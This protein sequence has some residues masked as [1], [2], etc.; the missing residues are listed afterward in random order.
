MEAINQESREAKDPMQVVILTGLSGAGKTNAAAWFE[1]EGYYCVDNMPPTLIQNFLE[2]T[3]SSNQRID[4]AAFVVD[5]RGGEFFDDLRDCIIQLRADQD[6]DCKVL[7]IEANAGTLVKRYNETRRS[8]PLAKGATTKAV[9]QKEIKQ[10]AEIRD[11]ADHI[12]D[13]TGMKVSNLK[14]AIGTIFF[15]DETNFAINIMSFGYKNGIPADIDVVFDMRFIPN[16]YYEP[17]LKKL[18]GKNKRVSDYVLK[19]KIAG[20]FIDELKILMETLIPGYIKEGKY[21]INMAF[22]CTG[23]RHRSVAMAAYMS[24]EFQKMGYQVTLEH[25]DV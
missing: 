11:M 14:E 5:V 1:D 15:G 3:K 2:L 16:P 13:T 8:H 20:D 4:R 6:I 19:Q 9:I 10:L 17:S 25:R 22:G 7:F 18:T 21:H 24:K 12:I 23:G